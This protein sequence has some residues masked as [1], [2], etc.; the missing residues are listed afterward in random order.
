MQLPLD[1]TVD[2]F[3]QLLPSQSSQKPA[4]TF[5]ALHNWLSRLLNN[6]QQQ[7][8]ER[9]PYHKHPYHLR[10]INIQSVDWFWRNRP[11]QEDKLGFMKII[12]KIETDSYIHEGED[13]ARPDWLPGA[14]FLRGGSVAMLVLSNRLC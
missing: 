2:E 4:Y 9:H 12:S 6:L 7:E 11:G 1:L 3:A 10:E 14:V 5:P 13:K 8:D